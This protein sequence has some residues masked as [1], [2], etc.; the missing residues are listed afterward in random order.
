MNVFYESQQTR[1]ITPQTVLHVENQNKDSRIRHSPRTGVVPSCAPSLGPDA[2]LQLMW[3]LWALPLWQADAW[4]ISIPPLLWFV[5]VAKYLFPRRTSALLKM[6]KKQEDLQAVKLELALWWD[7]P[8]PHIMWLLGSVPHLKR[9][10]VLPKSHQGSWNCQRT[11]RRS[12]LHAR[13]PSASSVLWP[14]WGHFF[15]AISFIDDFSLS[16]TPGLGWQ[17]IHH[18]S[19]VQKNMA[20]SLTASQPEVLKN[21]NASECKQSL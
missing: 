9:G 2:P 7:W 1:Q 12:R 16:V 15:L 8:E 3:F 6:E 4:F 10:F 18:N 11:S 14:S 19:E 13:M 21:G 5:W 17:W 20:E